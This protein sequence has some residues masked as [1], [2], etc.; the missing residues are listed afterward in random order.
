V[1][2]VVGGFGNLSTFYRVK[3]KGMIYLLL[4]SGWGLT[5]IETV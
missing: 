4:T 5:Y 1:K 3:L 2:L